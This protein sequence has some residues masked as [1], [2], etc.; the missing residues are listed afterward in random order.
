MASEIN[1]QFATELI[2]PAAG[3]PMESVVGTQ[4]SCYV[5]CFT[6]D[7]YNM[8]SHDPESFPAYFP[9]GVASSCL[10][11]RVSWFYDLHGPSMTVDT[12]CSSSL[13]AL[14]LA[15]QS[16]RTG[17]SQMSLVGGVNF[18]VS[19]EYNV[20]MSTLHFLSPD[21]KSQSFDEKGNGYARG[22]GTSFIVIKPLMDAIRDND[23]IRAVIRN[24]GSNQDGNT[25]G[26][27]LPSS[28]AQ[29][30]LICSTY[31]RAGLPLCDTG[32]FEAHGTG[33]AAGD[34]IE[35]SALGATF[36]KARPDGSPL[37]IGSIKANIGHLEGASGLAGLTKALYVLEKGLIPPQVWLDNV[38][39][40]ILLDAWNLAIPRKL[41]A[42]P[43]DGLRRVSVNSFG[44]GG[45][46]AHCIIDDAYH[47]L[48]SRGLQ[49]NHNTAAD[50][51]SSPATAATVDSAVEMSTP[52]SL[53]DNSEPN[54][55]LDDWTLVQSKLASVTP[56]ISVLSSHEQ[57]GI[58]RITEVLGQYLKGKVAEVDEYDHGKIL[59]R[60][61]YTTSTRRSILPWKSFFIASSL[62]EAHDSLSEVAKPIRSSKTLKL[63]F[64]FTGQG[65]Q[66]FA[67]GRELWSYEVYADSLRAAD[68]YLSSIGCEWSLVRELWKDAATSR[69]D[70][71]AFSQPICTAVQVALVELLHHW[72][73]T[74]AAVVGHS[75]GEIAAAFA[76]GSLSRE[77][78]WSVSYH[79]GRLSTMIKELAPELNGAMLAAGV[80]EDAAN[81]YLDQVTEGK[82]SVA[83]VN[84]P[85][86]VTIS[87]D[88]SAVSQVEK[89]LK[90]EDIFARKL[91]VETAYHSFHME[92]IRKQYLESMAGMQLNEERPDMPKMFSSV[93]GTLIKSQDLGPA[94][95][96]S[97]M[98]NTVRFAPAVDGLLQHSDLKKRRA[99]AK[100]YVEVMLEL[101]PHG[102]LQGPL[103]QILGDRMKDCKVMSALTRGKNCSHSALQA[104]GT[105]FQSGYPVNLDAANN[106]ERTS[107]KLGL[108][109]DLPPY[110]WNHTHK[111]WCE[112][113]LAASYRFRKLP[114]NDLLGTLTDEWNESEPAWRHFFRL[115][116]NPWI[117]DHSVHN[118]LL[119]PAAG[120]MVM[121]LEA[122]SQLADT[123]MEVEGYELRDVLIGKAMIVPRDE[124]GVETMVHV[125]PWR[126]GSQA[127]TTAWNEFTIY[128]R[129]GREAWS[130]NCSGLLRVVYKQN[131]SDPAFQDE[132]TLT[133]NQ[134]REKYKKAKAESTTT[135]SSKHFYDHQNKIGLQLGV[136][137]RNLFEINK[138][139]GQ[140][141]C[142]VRIPHMAS[143][144]PMNYI[145]K[146]VIHPC[147]LD[148]IIQ[149]LLPTVEGRYENLKT[150]AIPTY[151]EKLYVSADIPAEPETVFQTYSVATYTGLKEA[152]ASVYASVEGWRK[153]FVAFERIRATRLS[154]MIGGVASAAE[155]VNLRKIAGEFHW[156]EDVSHMTPDEITAYC[157][158]KMPLLEAPSKL[159]LDR[160]DKAGLIYADRALQAVSAEEVIESQRGLYKS[161]QEVHDRLSARSPATRVNEEGTLAQMAKGSIDG[162]L[163]SRLGRR[164]P[165]ILRGQAVPSEIVSHDDIMSKYEI[166]GQGRPQAVSQ[167]SSYLGLL[168]HHRPGMKILEVNC[169]YGSITQAAVGVL[170]EENDSTPWC[171]SY[172]CTSAQAKSLER[173]AANFPNHG[174]YLTFQQL[175][176]TKDPIEQGFKKGQYDLIIGSNF[177]RS[178]SVTTALENVKT[179]LKPGGKLILGEVMK[180]S[181]WY[182]LIFNAI[183]DGSQTPVLLE[184]QWSKRL[185]ETGYTGI[186]FKLPDLRDTEGKFFSFFASTSAPTTERVLPSDV[187]IVEGDHP[188][189]D[190]IELAESL[191]LKLQSLGAKVMTSS[192]ENAA[193]LDLKGKACIVLAEVQHPLLFHLQPQQ[194]EAIRT[195]ILGAASTT[196]VTRG[197]AIACKNPKMS[198]ITGLARSIRQENMGIALSTIDLDP[199]ILVDEAVNTD[200]LIKALHT[201]S[202]EHADQEFAVRSAL[203]MVPRVHL[204]KG[205]NDL[206]ATHNVEPTPEPGL[207]KQEGRALTLTV[208][209]P[210][211]LDTLHFKDDESWEAPI[212]SEE[213]E[214]QVKASGLNFMD[215]MVAMDQIQEPAIG[216]ECSGVIT[217]VGS[218]VTKFKKGDRAMTWLLDGFSNYARNDQSMFQPIP[219]NMDFETAAS[220]PMIYS[221]AYQS[222]V[223][224]A[225][226]TKE[227]KI[228]IHAAAGGVGQAAIMIAQHIG[229]EIF[230]TVG[231]QE[232]KRHIMKLYGILED[233][234]FNSRDL[235]FVNGIQRM[236][237]G[238][239]VDVILNSLAGEALRKSW[240]CL[241]WFG[242]FIELGKKDI[243]KFP[244]HA[245]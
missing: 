242:R 189:E 25:P 182:Q 209:V 45:A 201:H 95:W 78:A 194:F 172:T 166:Q 125:K 69:I 80:G 29:A 39:P 116:E 203:F 123:A 15:C 143:T 227:D 137:F 46:N 94:Y 1:A 145:T 84:G 87:G 28:D 210:G 169:K 200:A 20:T 21:G 230:A 224:E 23:T 135:E 154:S 106:T 126:M 102:A 157:A 59:E 33:T 163:L 167:L 164:L 128:S 99:N 49:A 244:A 22:E 66:H 68:A 147:T 211:M 113:A 65:A 181:S 50:A 155:S 179:L 212:R 183:G 141:A 13:V 205:V 54:N 131:D 240:H 232:K 74:P 8:M 48:T 160:L 89:L 177:S 219:A 133:N 64:V 218:D 98:L 204:H 222:L 62:E 176:I 35:T 108:L 82:A 5:G 243:S 151:I 67:M 70:S 117:E 91:K 7:Y 180:E 104:A 93:T 136:S 150:A 190:A 124:D 184:E 231:S 101:G 73:I 97:N 158:S 42:W 149:T 85:S 245:H 156:K 202:I 40:R 14:H 38:N 161:L 58:S 223:E 148:A 199:E 60:L 4:T 76:K 192:L 170:E 196:W 115:S 41:M 195:M 186:D 162:E 2:N 114:R 56:K 77:H 75:S 118:T 233:H 241:A 88:D 37:Y 239:G 214:I 236:T 140:S 238:K 198:L 191:S 110:A 235:D 34:P 6:Q 24:T 215:V 159:T 83:C 12:A 173:I 171:K 18:M 63:G 152:E 52:P 188:T 105:L 127:S 139:D 71:P 100:P 129:P 72:G 111:Y 165:D 10:S 57:T 90:A 206:I 30:A 96:V 32:Y 217:R 3:I 187:V 193:T 119:Y 79:R 11:N 17:E 144:M 27:T 26:I 130:L 53:N 122:A 237:A 138:G 213:I 51:N 226:L 134:H 174:S 31:A 185:T 92:V 234:I 175:N 19:P 208:G 81:K 112:S 36:G 121:A 197:G 9:T 132:V 220:L 86:S 207:F 229:A 178:T 43:A 47:Y 16:L 221:T 109:V 153:P 146:H 107:K 228:L 55:R 168:A 103:K 225:R 142:A 61:A 44:F 216:L 120:M